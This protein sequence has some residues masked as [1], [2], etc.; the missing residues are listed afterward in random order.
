[1][2]TLPSS[3]PLRPLASSESA[4]GI[5]KRTVKRASLAELNSLDLDEIRERFAQSRRDDR[6]PVER[7][8]DL[9]DLPR[10]QIAAMI[11][12]GLERQ[13]RERGETG[14]FGTGKV[15]GSDVLRAA[16]IE[17]RVA[18]AVLGFGADVL[19]DP[20][21]YIGPAGWGLKA[22]NAA[23][24]GVRI[25]L[26][27]QRA[28]KG[29]LK[30]VQKGE[31]VADPGTAALFK[32]SGKATAGDIGS[33][34]LGSPTGG[35]VGQVLSRVGGE[36]SKGGG[37]LA[38]TFDKFGLKGQAA[39]Q[40]DAARGFVSQYGKG[41]APG[42]RIGRD[43]TGKLRITV[44]Q[45]KPDGPIASSTVAHIPFTEW[46]IHVPAFT[47]DGK[48]A[49][50]AL[51]IATSTGR[52]DPVRAA[53]PVVGAVAGSVREMQRV[54]DAHARG[55]LTADDATEQMDSLY[56]GMD[57]ALLAGG[58][59]AEPENIGDLLSLKKLIHEGESAA[60]WA[61]AKMDAGDLDPDIGERLAKANMRYADSVRGSVKQ[62]ASAQDEETVRIAKRLLETDDDIIGS[63]VLT[64]FTTAA[65]AAGDP[66]IAVDI[67]NRIDNAG[68]KVFGQP[69][70]QLRSQARYL[71]N[72]LTTGSREVF[73]STER[74]IRN[75]V[76]KAMDDAG[77][78]LRTA[79]DYEKAANV[80]FALMYQERNA[81]AAA[82]GKHDEFWTKKFGTQEDADWVQLLDKAQKDGYF[83]QSPNG[84]ITDRLRPV[85]K[86][87]TG[88]LDTL[89]SEEY[90]DNILAAKL[91]GYV[92]TVATPEAKFRIGANKKYALVNP[93]RGHAAA[94]KAEQEAFQ[95]HRSTAQYRFTDDTGKAM[96][97]FEKDRWVLDFSP[98]E[99]AAVRAEDPASAARIEELQKTVANYDRMAKDAKWARANQPRNTD[100]W[101]LNEMVREGDFSLLLGGD[102][103]ATNFADTNIA[104]AMASRFMSHERA[105]ARRTWLEYV[106]QFGVTVDP[107]KMQGEFKN[108]QD[109]T[110][111]DGSVA[112]FF[113]DPK[114]GVYG[115]EQM[116]Q[117]YRPLSADVQS[118]KGNPLLEAMG[119]TVAKVYHED[120]AR[121]IEDLAS[122]YEEDPAGLLRSMDAITGAW[123]T[124]VLFSPTWTVGNIVGDGLNYIAGGAR[125]ADMAKQAAPIGRIIA[126][127]NNPEA[128]RGLTVNIRGV[129]IPAEQF[130]ADLRANRLL[131][132][133][134]HAET[135][136]Q[137]LNR[138]FFTMASTVAGAEG[139]GGSGVVGKL[140]A[141]G[142]D[143]APKMLKA[144]FLQ[145][146]SHETA[147]SKGAK[148][149]KAAGFI[150]RDRLMR[151]LIGPWFRANE[152]VSDYMR[153]LA[154]A[155]FLEQ[156]NDIPAAVQ[157]TI[158]AGFD[159]SDMSRT[160]RTYFRRM[161]P[162]Y[163]WMRLN[164]AYQLKLLMQRPIYAGSFPLL[165]NAIEEGLAGDQ[166]V[167]LHARPAW[168]RN[169]LAVMVGSDP[170]E[171]FALLLGSTLPTEQAL[172]A[173]GAL[174]GIEG[175]Q[176]FAKY[177]LT[178]IN[179]T[180]RAPAEFAAGREFFSG[181][182]IDPEGDMT[183]GQ[184]AAGQFRP[185]REA[186][187]LA[188]TYQ[189]QGLGPTIARFTLGGRIQNASDDRLHTARLREF[190]DQERKL[191]VAVRRADKN[192]DIAGRAVAGAKLLALY[193]QML[194]AGF[195][196]D[197]PKWAQERLS[198]M[199][200]N[201]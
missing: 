147:A 16:G 3:D 11:A 128:L 27:G 26:R 168:M 73:T 58:N 124:S 142:Q 40:A 102:D 133:N 189:D 83:S 18:R 28:I 198:A 174:T 171:R 166:Q 197:T 84:S 104:T 186:G 4:A 31:A 72:T 20:L 158:R 162:F 127:A 33:A 15:Y 23:G 183:P 175:V 2:S 200:H 195:E 12:P 152:K 157:R 140:K 116:G 137:L 50:D 132:N 67:A 17:N 85:A 155:S 190:Q 156:G 148:V 184:F 96:R 187:K 107:A 194:G 41:S 68:R 164:G 170:E 42:I 101:E 145:R 172:M 47:G 105:V 130:V 177:L 7:G 34:V 115:F 129:D 66:G 13:A 82:L 10:N 201:P 59:R 25:G 75:A 149:G 46:G 167:P 39:E 43:P 141:V 159:Y 79:E 92:P 74:E 9:L 117:R 121:Q 24:Q 64:P 86:Q 98:A 90:A 80:A 53:G 182:T 161:F 169:Q 126:N 61:K 173:T 180:I 54:A 19:V 14:A 45:A 57:Q 136:L 36:Q 87:Y 111:K 119:D 88:A 21:T 131:G 185:T 153:A 29:G 114:T 113:R 6:G 120:V 192:Q 125:M 1:M 188:K 38:E 103:L 163:S 199:T 5:G 76:I 123:K 60:E 93:K 32:A 71:R 151:R 78:E 44:G 49:G 154:Y 94:V 196:A 89:G 97:F 48:A 165:Q 8:L 122:L 51:R 179:P 181:R 77:M 95:K 52:V 65:R 62:F 112:K 138:K 108:G 150:A 91:K 69:S 70:G 160:E 178:S 55:F 135:A 30:A 146:L 191:Q 144:D 118:I 106:K 63:S 109:F 81:Q 143:F 35:K 99:L 22:T 56:R 110:L 139:R 37:I 176:D 100:P 193:Q 134:R